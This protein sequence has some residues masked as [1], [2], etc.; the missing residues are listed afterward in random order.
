M[1]QELWDDYMKSV[2]KMIFMKNLPTEELA[3]V[4]NTF[5]NINYSKGYSK[6]FYNMINQIRS[7]I[8]RM[9]TP[10]FAS[11]LF[12]LLESQITDVAI[13][14]LPIIEKVKE[15]GELLTVF[16]TNEDRI[17]LIWSLLILGKTESLIS[18]DDLIQMLD[19]VNMHNLDP[20][21]FRIFVQ[22]LNLSLAI[23]S[24][25]QSIDYEKFYSQISSLPSSTIEEIINSDPTSL[26]SEED[27][28]Q[29]LE[30][31]QEVAAE[32][33]PQRGNKRGNINV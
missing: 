5:T 4:F 8:Y 16:A 29:V 30:Q 13:K 12:S 14:F 20:Q 26:T 28:E 6:L 3:K 31:V 22:L 25:Q 23:P 19:K 18:S 32:V 9:P 33:I 17:K 15:N 10:L 21:H 7:G 27:R 1:N 2:G 11:T 24:F